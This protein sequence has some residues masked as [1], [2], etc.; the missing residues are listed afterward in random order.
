[1]TDYR[2]AP[3]VARIAEELIPKDHPELEG[4]RIE[5]VF[6][7]PPAT[8]KGKQVWGQ[9]KKV[10]GLSAYLAAPE[11]SDQRH[12][13]DLFVIEIAETVWAMLEP[14]QRIALVDHELSHCTIDVDDENETF[15]LKTVAHDFEEFRGVIERHGLWDGSLQSFAEAA[16]PHLT[17]DDLV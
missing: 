8:S 16:R 17:A 12:A 1:M 13:E 6:R 14:A 5:Y 10:T 9:A 15:T 7:D 11:E 4:V 2:P 3:A